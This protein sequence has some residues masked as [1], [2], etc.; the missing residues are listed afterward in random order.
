MKCGLAQYKKERK[1]PRK[2]VW[3]FLI[4]PRPHWYFADPKG[5]KRMR[6]HV[7]RNKPGNDDE[8]G[9]ADT[10]VAA[11]FRYEEIENER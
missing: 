3:Y 10:N 9:E 2:M 8:N 4:T 5:A 7:E 1:A 6:W 11:P